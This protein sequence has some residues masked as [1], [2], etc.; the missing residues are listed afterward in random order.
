MFNLIHILH[1]LQ[2]VFGVRFHSYQTSTAK[3]EKRHETATYPYELGSLNEYF[4]IQLHR[5][6][7][8]KKNK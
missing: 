3:K 4:D 5:N 8:K 7:N 2:A 1:R 6:W